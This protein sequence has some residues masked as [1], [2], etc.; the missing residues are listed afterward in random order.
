MS[1]RKLMKQRGTQYEITAFPFESFWNFMMQDFLATI[2][3]NLK[4]AKYHLIKLEEL[5]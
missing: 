3:K 4:N 2:H 1:C 5:L